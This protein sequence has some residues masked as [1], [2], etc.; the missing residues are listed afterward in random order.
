[1]SDRPG[2]SEVTKRCRQQFPIVAHRSDTGDIRCRGAHP[3]PTSSDSAF[4][5]DDEHFDQALAALV[6]S[7]TDY[8]GDPQHSH[9]EIRHEDG[10]ALSTSSTQAG[11]WSSCRRGR[12]SDSGTPSPAKSIATTTLNWL[13]TFGPDFQGCGVA[14]SSASGSSDGERDIDVHRFG[15]VHDAAG[16]WLEG[17]GPGIEDA[18]LCR[19]IS[20]RE[21]NPPGDYFAG[22]FACGATI[23]H[24]ASV[25]DERTRGVSAA[26]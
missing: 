2:T 13:E 4:L 24:L 26:A 6:E 16:G 19:W 3:T 22:G 25:K 17:G 1:M 21:R 12:T 14:E 15:W 10:A 7:R 8:W 18:G 9:N 5:V 20:M 11:T 23:S